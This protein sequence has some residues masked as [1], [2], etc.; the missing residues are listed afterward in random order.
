MQ[1]PASAS[2]RRRILF[3]SEAV[4][5]AHVGRPAALLAGL[6]GAR[7]EGWIACDPRSRRF[8]TVASERFV[9]IRSLD[10]HRFAERLRQGRPVYEAA[11]LRDHVRADLALIER[12]EPDLVVGD[13][14]LSLSVSARLARVPYACI[15][16]AYWSPY[17]PDRSLPLPVLPWT[18][19][20]PLA[21]AQR[22]FDLAQPLA[23]AGHCRALNAVR[24][25]HG[26]GSLGPDLRTVYTDADHTLYADS[27]E[28]FPLPSAPPNHR[29]LGPVLWSPPG[30]PP[31]WW[32]EV[33]DDRPV[34]Y[35]TMGSSGSAQA[36]EHVIDALAG[37]NVSIVGSTAGAALP[38]G[39]WRNVW[40]A[41]YLPGEAAAA[42]A[43][44]VVC[45]GGSPTSQQ[46]VAVGV[47]V[48]GIC[49]NMDQMLNMRGLVA[50]GLGTS[51]RADRLTPQL[52]RAAVEAG[53][54]AEVRGSHN[55]RRIS[56]V[57]PLAVRFLRFLDGIGLG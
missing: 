10:S 19:F 48:V 44:V 18:R 53:L 55:L 5:L 57:P 9:P 26:L 30:A 39:R 11:E 32:S 8:I 23:L 36:L 37:L 15:S 3:V 31:P 22:M 29:H 46:A 35:L 51:L 14:R 40:L 21:L 16:N 34:I 28:L 17:A 49:S 4:T 56:R 20:V 41:G 27:P 25:E 52:I 2:A 38:V 50:A 13:F 42:R 24:A 43:A 12:V 54:G 33:P 45:N 7:Y 47:P 6:D 1:P